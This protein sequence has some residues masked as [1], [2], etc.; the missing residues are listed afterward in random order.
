VTRLYFRSMADRGPMRRLAPLLTCIAVGFPAYGD[1]PARKVL[2]EWLEAFN[3]QDPSKVAAFNAAHSPPRPILSPSPFRFRTGGFTVVRFEEDKPTTV[4]ALVQEKNSD[5]VALASL[6]LTDDEAGKIS[7]FGVRLVPRPK[8]IAIKRMPIGEVLANTS[9]RVDALAA[10]DLFAGVVMVAKAGKVLLERA[11]GFSDR[12]AK[13]SISTDTQFHIG[14]M[15]KMFTSVAI[16]QLVEA[17]KLSLDDAVG[18]HL[19]DYPEKGVAEKVT[20]RHL[21]THRGGTG[22][23]FTAEY[24]TKRAEVRTLDDYVKL[25][26]ARPLDHEPGTSFRYSNYGYILLGLI[27]EKVAGESYYDYVRKKIFEPA[28]MAATDSMPESELVTP[29]SAGYMW[30]SDGWRPNTDTL[31]WR[32][33]SAG[34]G[35]STARDLIKF[36]EALEQGKLISKTLLAEATK[37]Q[38]ESYGFGFGVNG[39]GRLRRYGH[40]GGAPGMNGELRI[41]PES[42]Y[43]VVVLSNLDPP[44]A[45]RVADFLD[46][47][48]SGD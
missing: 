35:Y 32:G 19:T 11:V 40:G 33:T 20:I 16:L 1:V 15:N 2:E 12:D 24:A 41:Y 38:V 6:S 22:D 8:D 37:A 7:A 9:A 18:K 30:R 36:A 21:L 43:F 23:I 25:F 26:G 34:G 39:E 10:R 46:D 45:T 48:M 44:A 42:G 47:R 14:S 5:A 31:P 3:S 27:V 17:G 13:R 29:R 28:G 4:V